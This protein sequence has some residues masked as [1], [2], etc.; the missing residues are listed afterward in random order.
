MNRLEDELVGEQEKYKAITG[1]LEAT[2]S[3]CPIHI[4]LVQTIKAT[5]SMFKVHTSVY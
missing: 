5:S 2:L 3:Y 4:L 1:E